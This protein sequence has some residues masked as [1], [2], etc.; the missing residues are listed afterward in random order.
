MKVLRSVYLGNL[1]Q[2]E[3]QFTAQTC[4]CVIAGVH[5]REGASNC[6]E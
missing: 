1:R 6:A 4:L 5:K 2:F 3:Y